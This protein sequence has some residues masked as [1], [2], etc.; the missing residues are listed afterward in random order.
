MTQECNLRKHPIV[1]CI[2]ASDSGGGAGMQADVHTVEDLGCHACSVV[3]AVTAQNSLG[4]T[5]VEAVS[6]AILLAQLDT[7]L[8]DM[9]PVAIKIGLIA[10]QAQLN[11]LAGWLTQHLSGVPIVLDPVLCATTGHDFN[12]TE[13]DFGP[14]LTLIQVFTPNAFEVGQLC[15]TAC[16]TFSQFIDA[17]PALQQ[18][19]PAHL[20]L[21][22][23]DLA[24]PEWADDLLFLRQP[25]FCAEQHLNRGFKLRSLRIATKHNHGS[26]CTLSSAIAALIAQ[27]W[28][29]PDAIVIAKAYVHSGLQNGYPI[30]YG[31]GVIAKSGF[32]KN[33]AHFP[34]VLP[35]QEAKAICRNSLSAFQFASKVYPIVSNLEQLALLLQCGCRTLQLRMKATDEGLL[36]TTIKQAVALAKRY[37]TQLFIND[38]WQLALKYQAYGV[39]LGQEDFLRADLDALKTAGIV[40]GL[41]SHSYFEALIALEQQPDYLALGHIFPTTTKVMPSQPQGLSRLMHYGATFAPALATVAIGGINAQNLNDIQDCGVQA[42]AIVSAVIHA[43]DPALAYLTL[44]RQWQ[45]ETDVEGIV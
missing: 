38:H 15:G 30:G 10:D 27:Q 1:W 6:N 9:R 7:L 37:Q 16:S 36:D 28:V 40:L 8:S 13:L 34:H 12:R 35:L 14:L 29:I 22:G 43:N 18:M 41:S 26:G 23:G 11:C 21:K 3:T 19:T 2:S 25:P 5:S 39:H 17:L 44:A 42:A 24:E 45:S 20:L 32:P 33:V 31:A 4:V